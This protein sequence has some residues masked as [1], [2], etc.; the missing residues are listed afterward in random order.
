MAI[1]EH[2]HLENGKDHSLRLTA[3]AEGSL[4]RSSPGPPP[5]PSTLGG[6]GVATAH[7]VLVWAATVNVFVLEIVPYRSQ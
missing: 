3:K 4:T 6:W 5:T 2:A 1:L 7:S